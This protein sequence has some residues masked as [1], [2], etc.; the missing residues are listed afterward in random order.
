MHEQILPWSLKSRIKVNFVPKMSQIQLRWTFETDTHAAL[1]LDYILFCFMIYM[2]H[3]YRKRF[4]T[5]GPLYFRIFSWKIQTK[6]LRMANIFAN[7]NFLLKM[8]PCGEIINTATFHVKNSTLEAKFAC[9][10]KFLLTNIIDIVISIVS[11]ISRGK[12]LGLKIVDA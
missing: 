5:K 3:Y 4:K 7:S 12:N 6:D 2:Y 8:F 11:Q 1:L 10:K 9:K